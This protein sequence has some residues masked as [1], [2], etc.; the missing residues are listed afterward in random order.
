MNATEALRTLVDA[1]HDVLDDVPDGVRDLAAAVAEAETA[2]RDTPDC[3]C[4][5]GSDF[6]NRDH[7]DHC[8]MNT[9]SVRCRSCG[10]IMADVDGDCCDNAG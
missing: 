7:A 1:A 6:P 2:L 3:Q 8:P 4:S 10:Q 9:A 5:T